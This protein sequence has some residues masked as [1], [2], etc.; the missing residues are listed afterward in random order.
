MVCDEN[1]LHLISVVRKS[2]ETSVIV[3]AST[4]NIKAMVALMHGF[5]LTTWY[6]TEV[7]SIT[8]Y[9]FKEKIYPVLKKCELPYSP[10]ISTMSCGSVYEVGIFPRIQK[11][12]KLTCSICTKYN[13][14]YFV[15]QVYTEMLK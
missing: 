11:K 6:R 4:A 5:A 9:T 7:E 10:Q 12:Q 13:K 2:P 1:L 8:R 14:I 15:E 3:S